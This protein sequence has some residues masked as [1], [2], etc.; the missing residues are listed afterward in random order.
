[1]VAN[2]AADRELRGLQQGDDGT[3]RCWWCGDDPEYVRYHDE[4]WG[5]EVHDD[6]RLFEKL[7]LEGF[8]AGLAWIT[9]LRKRAAFRA[10][11]ADFDPAVVAGFGAADVDRLL[12]D[13][14]IVR[15]RGKIEATIA[16]ARA[17]HE[18]VATEGSLDA[19]VWRFAPQS[20]PPP[21]RRI[22]DIP[23]VT[24][25]SVALSRDLKRRGWR[26]V[27]PTTAYAFMQSMGLVDDH[28]EGCA[29]R[30]G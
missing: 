2:D 26:F 9:I 18:L 23:A 13:A 25:E 8:Q 6:V 15:H 29:S 20:P 10:A 17:Y 11:F 3:V 4:E 22:D 27:G 14:G 24:P 16:N 5:I 30:S 19:Y 28:L 7:C 1:V 12:A 21:P